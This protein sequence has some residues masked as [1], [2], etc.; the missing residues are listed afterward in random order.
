MSL[1]QFHLTERCGLLQSHDLY[2]TA[3]SDIAVLF[4]HT[5]TFL[6]M[7]NGPWVTSTKSLWLGLYLHDGTILMYCGHSIM[8]SGSPLMY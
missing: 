1:R 8:S 4:H 2:F 7:S 3:F 6:F 5:G